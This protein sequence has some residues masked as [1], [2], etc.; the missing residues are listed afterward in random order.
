MSNTRKDIEKSHEARRKIL[1]HLRVHP[2][3]S[4]D[5][6]AKSGLYAPVR[7]KNLERSSR[8]WARVHV[9]ALLDEGLVE[10]IDDCTPHRFRARKNGE[11]I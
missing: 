1:E 6:I 3:L 8:N 2:N 5:E 4:T 9:L 11:S 10:R 7:A